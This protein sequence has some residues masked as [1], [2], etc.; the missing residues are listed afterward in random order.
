MIKQK[1]NRDFY[2]ELETLNFKDIK[3]SLY[4]KIDDDYIPQKWGKDDNTT[5]GIDDFVYAEFDLDKKEKF[6]ITMHNKEMLSLINKMKIKIGND[7]IYTIIDFDNGNLIV[8][9]L[10][11]LE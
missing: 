5:Y 2:N 8:I 1:L 9:K 4:N 10:K 11:N 3:F 6:L 7:K